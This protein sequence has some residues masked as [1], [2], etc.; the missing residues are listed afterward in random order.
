M[1]EGTLDPFSTEAR[2]TLPC[3]NIKTD[4]AL[5]LP[6]VV[7]IA[8]CN[9]PQTREMWA[10]ARA[11]AAQ[12]G[13][14]QASYLPA[15]SASLTGNRTTP[16]TSQRSVGL[17]LSYLL[18]DF[19]ARAANLEYARQ[20]LEAAIATQDNTIQTVFLA[21]VQAYY[22]ARATQAAF[23]AAVVSERAAQESFAAA[24][25]RYLAGSAT[26][27][28]KL[29]MQTAWSQA[30]LNRITTFGAM[31]I[32]QGNLAN[33]LGM[34][35]QLGVLLV[36]ASSA[37]PPDRTE[38]KI[39][40]QNIS[41]LVEEAR[42]KRPDLLA[43][44]A[45]VLAAQATADAAR[46]AAKPSISMTAAGNQNN[47]AGLTTQGSSL[48]LSVSVPLFSG[49]APT[50]RI[51]AAEAQIETKKAQLERIRLQVALDVWTA[52]QNLA[53]A[54]Q[55]RRTT[56]DLLESAKQSERV[57]SGRYKAGAGIM[58]D[59]LNAQNILANARQQRIQAELNWNIS[60]ATLAQAMG[61]LDA[62]ILH[63]LPDTTTDA[64]KP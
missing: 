21:A 54:T 15:I 9:N 62:G 60:R 55:N 3:A 37:A 38:L 14:N 4:H 25:A 61:S 34:D 22:Q 24:Q 13:I 2:L 56:T 58:L 19:G 59:L 10:S 26:P 35:A 50:Y 48:G 41:A 32:A 42:R 27:A 31:K 6:A 57:A 20:L 47:S 17:S 16:G 11:Q 1:A 7:N 46:A 43:A 8:L 44:Q 40:E 39:L 64:P 29:T 5:D 63:T 33:I 45:Q 52:Y 49:Y 12:V 51:R 18:Y 28:D 30:T 36:A 53:T 23:D